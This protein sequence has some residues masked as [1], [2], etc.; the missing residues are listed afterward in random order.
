MSAGSYAGYIHRDA[1][2]MQSYFER[3]GVPIRAV[4]LQQGHSFGAWRE[5]AASM[6]RHFFPRAEGRWFRL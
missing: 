1:R 3:A 6:L 5:S 2:T 4:Y